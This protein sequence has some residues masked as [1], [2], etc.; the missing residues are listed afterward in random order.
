[1]IRDIEIKK[2]IRTAKRDGGINFHD[3]IDQKKILMDIK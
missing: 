2:A 1:M 3:N